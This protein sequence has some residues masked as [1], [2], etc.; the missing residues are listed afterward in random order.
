MSQDTTPELDP[1]EEWWAAYGQ[2]SPFR[3][4]ENPPDP[5]QNGTYALSAL[6]W[7]LIALIVLGVGAG[8]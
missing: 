5:W 1:I 7:G 2:P 8:P 6:V 3:L 4:P